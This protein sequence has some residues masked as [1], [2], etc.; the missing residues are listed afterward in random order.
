MFVAHSYWTG[1]GALALRPR[2]RVR[3]TT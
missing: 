3:P 1:P 2:G